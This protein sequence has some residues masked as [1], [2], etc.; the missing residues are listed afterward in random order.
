M[1]CRKLSQRG[2][3]EH[4]HHQV[5]PQQVRQ[6]LEDLELC[7]ADPDLRQQPGQR[8]VIR[9]EDGSVLLRPL[10]KL[11]RHNKER[12]RETHLVIHV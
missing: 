12:R 9:Q 1:D 10:F 4:L 7:M 8:R 2:D 5:G 6:H 11:E 3:T